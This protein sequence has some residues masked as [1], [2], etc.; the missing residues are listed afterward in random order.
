[1]LIGKAV[2]GTCATRRGTPPLRRETASD[3]GPFQSLLCAPANTER[4]R[5]ERTCVSCRGAGPR[6]SR[7]VPGPLSGGPR[8]SPRCERPPGSGHPTVLEPV[9]SDEHVGR[10]EVSSLPNDTATMLLPARASAHVCLGPSWP[11]SSVTSWPT[12]AS[13]LT[14]LHRH[15]SRPTRP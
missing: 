2:S 11:A 1:M 9:P 3:G 7:S 4:L 15:S 13:P 10:Y 8:P 5:P 6:C 12:P 14:S